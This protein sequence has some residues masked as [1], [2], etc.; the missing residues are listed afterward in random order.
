M[1]SGGQKARIAFARCLYGDSDIYIL[2]D[3]VAALDSGT[4][5]FVMKETIGKY[6]SGKT[7]ILTTHNLT[8]LP[9]SDHV[10]YM[11]EGIIKS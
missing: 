5:A 6:L 1:I 10:V 4:A 2:D 9:Y 8:T 3:I 7:V 11:E